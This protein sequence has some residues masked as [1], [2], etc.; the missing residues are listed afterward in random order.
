MSA[1][2]KAAKKPY[3]GPSFRIFDA[4]AAQAELKAKGR[5]ERCKRPE[6]VEGFRVTLVESWDARRTAL[7]PELL[8]IRLG[9]FVNS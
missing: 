8:S 2:P 1:K 3:S 7:A 6:N 5:P 9:G 4:R